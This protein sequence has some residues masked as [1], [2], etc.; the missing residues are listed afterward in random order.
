M[1]T[2]IFL[3]RGRNY[4]YMAE[5]GMLMGFAPMLE[6]RL[7]DLASDFWEMHGATQRG[8][9]LTME[10]LHERY[11]QQPAGNPIFEYYVESNM[12]GQDSFYEELDGEAL[13]VSEVEDIVDDF[14]ENLYDA[15]GPVAWLLADVQRRRM[16]A[17]GDT[18]PPDRRIAER[19]LAYKRALAEAKQEAARLQGKRGHEKRM[20]SGG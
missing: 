8:A 12:G 10:E 2:G 9:P 15:L 11:D 4:R 16:E 1:R 18:A 7:A 3:S 20:A 13:S 19:G 5:N 17:T 6:G 14:F